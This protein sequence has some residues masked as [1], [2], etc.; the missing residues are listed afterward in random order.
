M[1]PALADAAVYP[2]ALLYRLVVHVKRTIVAMLENERTRSS[3]TFISLY[4][5]CCCISQVDGEGGESLGGD[6]AEREREQRE[7]EQRDRERDSKPAVTSA[8][9]MTGDFANSVTKRLLSYTVAVGRQATLHGHSMLVASAV[10]IVHVII[11]F[12]RA[13]Q[14]ISPPADD[15]LKTSMTLSDHVGPG[16]GLA[17]LA[18]LET[19]VWLSLVVLPMGGLV[20]GLL[21]NQD[22][23]VHHQQSLTFLRLDFDTRLGMHS[24]R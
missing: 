15:E 11:F 1:K 19:V 20:V 5:W 22:D 23:H 14:R 9:E 8:Q 2:V 6:R 4:Y 7:R 12:L 24:P 16:S 3:V 13:W 10:L 17:M 21:T 18:T